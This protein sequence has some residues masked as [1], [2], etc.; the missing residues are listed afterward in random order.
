MAIDPVCG[1]EVVEVRPGN[2][3]GYRGEVYVFCSQSCLDEFK[4]NPETYSQ[5]SAERQG[6]ETAGGQAG[7]EPSRAAE[8][9]EIPIRTAGQGQPSQVRSEGA[10]EYVGKRVE[11]R[12]GH[13]GH[14][15]EKW[16]DKVVDWF[17]ERV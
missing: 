4:K 12:P 1:C 7:G 15:A 10:G 3:A 11:E 16:W 13:A 5:K 9:Q 17:K 2:S 6:Q 14:K 8:G